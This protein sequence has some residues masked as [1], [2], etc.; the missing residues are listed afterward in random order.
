MT[1]LFTLTLS[2]NNE[3]VDFIGSIFKVKDGGFDIGTVEADRLLYKVRP[4]FFRLAQKERKF[5]NSINEH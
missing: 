4:G 1:E 3:S 5:R 2:D